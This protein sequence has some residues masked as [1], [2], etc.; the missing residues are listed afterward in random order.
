MNSTT[1]MTASSTSDAD[2]Q[3]AAELFDSHCE[4]ISN[5][6]W[7]ICCNSVVTKFCRISGTIPLT[8][9]I[10]LVSFIYFRA[11]LMK[12]LGKAYIEPKN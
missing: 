2:Y 10:G 9:T 12:L 3:F 6:E 5:N 8:A 4:D 11:R 1:S 7:D